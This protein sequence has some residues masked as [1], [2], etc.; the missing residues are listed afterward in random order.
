MLTLTR[1][2]YQEIK[3]EIPGDCRDGVERPP[4]IITIVVKEIRR[5]QIR[6]GIDAPKH[7][8]VTRPE[9]GVADAN[10]SS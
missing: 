9:K 8:K 4:E 2:A 10:H 6:L 1:K 5:N 3:I 7:I